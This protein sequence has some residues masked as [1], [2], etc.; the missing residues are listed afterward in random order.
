ML[1]H[2]PLVSI[3]TMYKPVWKPTPVH[4]H[5][6]VNVYSPRC[7]HL[8][9][10][11]TSEKKWEMRVSCFLWPHHCSLL[12]IYLFI[13]FS[14][15]ELL[16]A[17]S[18][19]IHGVQRV[20]MRLYPL[21]SFT[22]PNPRTCQVVFSQ[23]STFVTLVS[24]W[25]VCLSLGS[26]AVGLTSRFSSFS[27]FQRIYGQWSRFIIIFFKDI[28]SPKDTYTG[29]KEVYTSES[30]P[31]VPNDLRFLLS[32]SLQQKAVRRQVKLLTWPLKLAPPPVSAP[33]CASLVVRVSGVH[34][35]HAEGE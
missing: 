35:Y 29:Y 25:I 11:D 21:L 1:V 3:H 2:P 32:W 9:G 27:K 17:S 26:D 12:E 14:L 19:V 6:N 28:N 8:W 16:L 13:Y 7:R 15:H 34:H 20:E 30:D 5:L 10:V 4:W 24:G 31:Q 22:V 33:G 23:V 18:T